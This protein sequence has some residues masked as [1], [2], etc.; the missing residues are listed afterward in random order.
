EDH[1][2]EGWGSKVEYILAT[3]GFAIGFGNVWRFPYLCQKNGGGAFLIPYFT[4]LVTMGIPLFFL[5]LAIGQSIRKGSIGVWNNIHPYLGGVGIASVVLSL[6][7]SIYYNVLLAWCFIYLFGAFQKELPYSSC[8]SIN[9]KRVAGTEIPECTFAG[10]TQYYWYKTALGVSSSLEEGG[11]LQWHLCLCLLLSWIIVFLCIMRGVKSGGKAV[12]VTATVPYIVL[13]IFLIRGLTLDGAVDGIKHMFT[14]Q[15]DKLKDP[16]VWLEAAT[17]IFFSLGIG[18]GSLIAM[19]SYNPIHNNCRRD[20]VFVSLMNCATSI[21]ATIVIFSIL[22]F[23]ANRSYDECIA[24]YGGVN[25]TLLPENKTM[26]DM[27]FNLEK[28]LNE[29]AGGPGLTFIAFTE[30]ILKMPISPLWAVLFFGMLIML[31]LSSQYGILEGV[32]T[33]IHEMKLVP[34][35]KEI[36]AGLLCVISFFVGL[37]FCQRSGEYW[38]QMFDSFSGPL[39]LLFVGLFELIGVAYVYGLRRFESD[40]E[41]MI[42]CRP[43]WYWLISWFVLS[44]LVVLAIIVPSVVNLAVKPIGYTVWD[45]AKADTK[46]LAYPWWGHIVIAFLIGSSCLFIPGVFVVR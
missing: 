3:I 33:P 12:Y 29:A 22:G 19:S 20:A 15:F 16:Q 10:R 45:F 28:W 35:R 46:I 11:G 23:K 27:C 9:G 13:T 5:E 39:P 31:G 37:V 17:Q 4:S 44:P 6:L 41:Y 42:G 8:P 32:V 40:I 43:G 36:I 18:Y 1:H 21:Y 30:A 26:A 24:L 14:P 34:F 7:I 2:R 38:L 25:G